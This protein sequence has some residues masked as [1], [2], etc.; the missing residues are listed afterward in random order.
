MK[1]EIVH[2]HLLRILLVVCCFFLLSACE[3]KTNPVPDFPVYLD[4]NIPALYPHFVPDNGFQTLVFTQK[5]YE[6]ELIGYAGVLVWISMDG[7]YYAADLCCSHCID[8]KQPVTPDGIFAVCPV[9][10]EQYDL[11][12]GLANPTKG[13]AKQTLRR[14]SARLAGTILQIRN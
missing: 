2:R 13:I 10:G 6:Y 14:F 3:N 7:R 11:S 8:H 12:Y 4:L 9:C 5:R 1:T